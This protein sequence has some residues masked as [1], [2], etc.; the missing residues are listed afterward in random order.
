MG[1]KQSWS[2]ENFSINSNSNSSGRSL[3]NSNSNSSGR[4]L[5]IVNSN[6][7][8]KDQQQQFSNSKSTF[9]ACIFWLKGI[10]VA[11]IGTDITL[12]A[13]Q[14]IMPT[15]EVQKQ[16]IPNKKK[17]QQKQSFLPIANRASY[18]QQQQ[19]LGNPFN[20]SNSNS[21]KN[22]NSNSDFNTIDQ[23]WAVHCSS[24][25][26]AYLKY[27]KL[28]NCLC[29]CKCFIAGPQSGLHCKQH[30]ASFNI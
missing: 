10:S 17:I 30:A 29:I 25:K 7:A 16:H 6:S 5:A 3:I 11:F 1:C 12:T 2:I 21:A 4:P 27:L 26:T 14:P 13:F 28:Q 8:K 24:Y 19:Q 22:V 15:A 20:N 9:H 23:L 18:Q